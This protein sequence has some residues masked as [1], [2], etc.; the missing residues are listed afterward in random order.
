MDKGRFVEPSSS[1]QVHTPGTHKPSTTTPT[2]ESEPQ[3]QTTT[4]S[5]ATNKS[6][7]LDNANTAVNGASVVP[8]TIAMGT[9]V[10]K[11]SATYTDDI[12]RIGQTA[13]RASRILGVGAIG[14][15]AVD[16]LSNGW[17]NHHTADAAIGAAQTF[18]LGSGPVGWGVSLGF[19][20][21]DLLVKAYSGKSITE[22]IFD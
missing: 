7:L 13:T 20:V 2:A 1:G 6:P 5:P 12:A 4:N 15:T 16:G 21:T 18:L 8:S 9:E 19:F 10:I 17:K 22:H 11:K 14:L 3:T